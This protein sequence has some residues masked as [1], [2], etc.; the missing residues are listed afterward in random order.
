MQEG[1]CGRWMLQMNEGWRKHPVHYKHTITCT[2]QWGI[3][4]QV[5][6]S[7]PRAFGRRQLA[8]PQR[9][10]PPLCTPVAPIFPSASRNKS[11]LLATIWGGKD[12]NFQTPSTLLSLQA[13]VATLLFAS[14]PRVP[15]HDLS[16]PLLGPR[17]RA[18]HCLQCQRPFSV[19]FSVGHH[20]S[21]A[22]HVLWGGGGRCT[23][24]Y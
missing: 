14:P 2:C 18:G 4:Q 24:N 17:H 13:E 1:E 15:S 11:P 12:H 3:E 6:A 22:H 21:K 8:A 16:Q 20:S 23:G 10:S 19:P 5:T 7:R 9:T